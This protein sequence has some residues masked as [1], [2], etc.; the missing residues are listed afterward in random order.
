M[1]YT[2]CGKSSARSSTLWND[3]LGLTSQNGGDVGSG[4]TTD[5]MCNEVCRDS[6][7]KERILEKLLTEEAIP[8]ILCDVQ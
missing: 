6:I 1:Q 3:S 7:Y 8:E 5:D 2:Y 4:R